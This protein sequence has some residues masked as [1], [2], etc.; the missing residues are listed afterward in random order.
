MNKK[1]FS[2]CLGAVL[3]LLASCSGGY[4]SKE[5]DGVEFTGEGV[6]GDVP[7]ICMDFLKEFNESFKAKVLDGSVTEAEREELREDCR[8]RYEEIKKKEIVNVP[9]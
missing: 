2:L 6:F 5:I 9:F 7:Y 4:S 3:L 1:V 8:S